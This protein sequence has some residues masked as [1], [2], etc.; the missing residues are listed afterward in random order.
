MK[1]YGLLIVVAGLVVVAGAFVFMQQDAGAATVVVY[2]SPTCTCCAKWVDHLESSGFDVEVHDDVDMNSV[3]A[4]NGVRP[5]YASCH[6]ALV[7]GYVI[8]GHVP[9]ATI[10]RL[11]AERPQVLGLT[12]P[13]M[14]AGSPGMEMPDPSQHEDFDV[15]TFDG[16]GRTNVYESIQAG[17]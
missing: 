2:K 4:Q 14:P 8:E 6:T 12:A 9:A 11:L 3:K 7:D 10:V 16:S 17:S 1:K 5:E 13:G 15:L